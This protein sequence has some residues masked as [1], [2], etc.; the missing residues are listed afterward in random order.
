MD[1]T[2]TGNFNSWT[3]KCYCIFEENSP[4]KGERDAEESAGINVTVVLL[5]GVAVASHAVTEDGLLQFDEGD[6]I[7][8]LSDTQEV[9]VLA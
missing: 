3:G 5:Q 8:V 9:S 4:L 2:D 6:V 7:L 1:A